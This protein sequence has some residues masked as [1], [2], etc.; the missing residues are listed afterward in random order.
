M[1]RLK[2]SFKIIKISASFP[3]SDVMPFYH[4]VLC[5]PRHEGGSPGCEAAI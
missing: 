3:E 5:D 1:D 2:G 4:H